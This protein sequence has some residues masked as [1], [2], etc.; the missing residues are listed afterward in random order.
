M[1]KLRVACY[2][3][4]LVSLVSC[5]AAFVYWFH[6]DLDP[7]A[8]CWFIGCFLVGYGIIRIVGFFSKDS[9]CLAFHFDFACGLL[10]IVLGVMVCAAHSLAYPYLSLGLGWVT[11][12]D[13]L[14][15]IQM[16]KEA[17][18]FG[19]ERWGIVLI[20]AVITGVV[21]VLLILYSLFSKNALNI[22]FLTSCT[23]LMEGIVNFLV[24]KIMVKRHNKEVNKGD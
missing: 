9:Y 22:R 3:Y 23:L 1:K 19:L 15:R 13:C 8:T 10:M 16:S 17:Q 6:P 24:V 14:F 12:M 2:G 5:A 18:D 7:I 11:L 4:L 21:S 20:A